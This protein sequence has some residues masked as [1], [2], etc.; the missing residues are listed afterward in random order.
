[1]IGKSYPSHTVIMRLKSLNEKTTVGLRQSEIS[2]FY[3]FGQSNGFD[4]TKM[5]ER[6]C[7]L[8]YE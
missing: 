1:M 8:C 7:L 3:C 5:K 2:V 4:I 6:L